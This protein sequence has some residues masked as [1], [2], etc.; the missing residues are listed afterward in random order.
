MIKMLATY[1]EKMPTGSET[2]EFLAIDLGGTNVRVVK[3]LL[4]DRKVQEVVAHEDAIP[5]ELMTG[6]TK[7]LFDFI[8]KQVKNFITKYMK[9]QSMMMKKKKAYPIGFTFSYPMR[10]KSINSGELICWTKGFGIKDTTGKCLVEL[11][12]NSLTEQKVN[13]TVFAILNDTVGTLAA[14]KFKDQDTQIGLIL[15]TG[16]NAA[17][18][19][20]TSRCSKLNRES[21]GSGSNQMI[22]NMEWGNYKS[23]HLP[24]MDVDKDIDASTLNKGAQ[25]YE[26]MISGMYLGEMARRICLKASKEINL[27]GGTQ[28]NKLEQEWS[29]PTSLVSKIDGL[30]TEDLHQVENLLSSTLNIS[31]KSVT[32]SDARF[33]AELCTLIGDRSAT[34]AGA[35]V[36]AIYKYMLDN[37]QVDQGQ[38]FVVAVDGGLFEHYPRYPDRM[39]Q[40]FIDLLGK[41][42]AQCIELVH[43]PDGSGIGSAVI[44]AAQC[45]S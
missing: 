35:G 2:G 14:N 5:K 16:S 26:K 10:Q 24:Y 11:L 12:Q 9:A 6:T 19:E 15:G 28:R 39:A 37:N 31:E 17:Y 40:T 8:A 34:L 44:A 41:K 7:Q 20:R 29:F 38:R 45:K 4:K 43:S 42:Q 1:V 18:I 33:V 21:G 36:V 13:G 22:I 23:S 27:F 25:H 30:G 32:E 3:V